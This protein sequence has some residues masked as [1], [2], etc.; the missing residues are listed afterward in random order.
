MRNSA[1]IDEEFIAQMSN[2]PNIIEL[3][4]AESIF[5]IR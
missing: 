4:D 3:N 1:G 5:D 2:K